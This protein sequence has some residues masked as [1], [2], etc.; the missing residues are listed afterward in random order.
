MRAGPVRDERPAWPRDIP[1]HRVT[2]TH[3]RPRYGHAR[4]AR[5]AWR[6]RANRQWL[7]GDRA[8]PQC[9]QASPSVSSPDPVGLLESLIRAAW[10]M[11]SPLIAGAK[12]ARGIGADRAP[13][14]QRKSSGPPHRRAGLW[15]FPG[16]N[17]KWVRY[18]QRWNDRE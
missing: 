6:T 8:M 18:N 10:L 1:R 15:Q 5:H 17:S 11:L 13:K 7:L 14:K 12:R 2:A 4:P 3:G 9:P 16:R